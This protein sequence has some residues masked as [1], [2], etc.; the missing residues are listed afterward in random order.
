[1]KRLDELL[2]AAIERN[3]SDSELFELTNIAINLGHIEKSISKLFSGGK[4]G[5]FNLRK[6]SELRK[7]NNA[8][9]KNKP[10]SPK[11]RRKGGIYVPNEYRGI[12]LFLTDHAIERYSQRINIGCSTQ[13]SIKILLESFSDAKKLGT[14]TK[15]G[16][17]QWQAKEGFVYVVKYD[18]GISGRN[19]K[20][21]RVCVT[22]LYGLE[23]I[24]G[25]D[26]EY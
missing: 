14:K 23:E 4:F 17:E 13:D 8:H 25:Q 2:Q 16:E 6:L 3:L 5:A 1:M 7:A 9:L 19:K 18:Y 22:I 11:T 24:D 21:K 15:N 10:S 20:S 12:E 26:S